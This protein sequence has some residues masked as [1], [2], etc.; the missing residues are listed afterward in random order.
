MT[1]FV[2]G[3][4]EYSRAAFEPA[5]VSG[6][7]YV[8]LLIVQALPF[9]GLKIIVD[10]R[11]RHSLPLR[12]LGTIDD[13]G[14]VLINNEGASS[15]EVREPERPLA[16][17]IEELG[18]KI[19]S[20]LGGKTLL[21][22]MREASPPASS[23]DDGEPTSTSISLLHQAIVDTV[24]P[25]MDH[26]PRE[27]MNLVLRSLALVPSLITLPASSTVAT[28]RP[29]YLIVLKAV[30]SS[31]D[32]FTALGP[33]WSL[34]P[35]RLFRAVNE[36]LA[37]EAASR[38]TDPT[39]LSA[40]P[41]TPIAVKR[42]SKIQWGSMNLPPRD[43]P[44]PF[45]AAVVP[46]AVAAPPPSFAGFSFSH[47]SPSHLPPSTSES[48]LF[49]PPSQF[50]IVTPARSSTPIEPL[51][52]S[53]SASSLSPSRRSSLR[54]PLPPAV[55]FT[56]PMVDALG[57]TTLLVGDDEGNGDGLSPQS[58]ADRLPAIVAP[59]D[60][61]WIERLLRDSWE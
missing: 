27:S 12:R 42:A 43:L 44:S 22:L 54:A 48:P 60:P 41:F 38:A 18:T 14:R 46:A 28:S 34:E 33:A 57:P 31:S 37:Q 39:T 47:T 19:A 6:S 25:L 1:S 36:N 10:A 2:S 21:T 26:V 52:Q 4:Q 55:Q 9:E 32:E 30:L 16:Q 23:K 24:V 35:F 56:H 20:E 8:G 49:S 7:V 45:P 29:C 5:V 61:A 40:P 15:D 3:L 17:S 13:E 11:L 58:A 59:Y 53:A 51:H 50:P